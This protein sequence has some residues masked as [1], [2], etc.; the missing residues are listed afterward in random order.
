MVF[1]LWITYLLPYRAQYLSES[2]WSSQLGE[3][4]QNLHGQLHFHHYYDF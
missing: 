4:F 1:F 3:E 2:G